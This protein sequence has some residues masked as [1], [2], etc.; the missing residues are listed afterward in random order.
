[1]IQIYNNTNIDKAVIML[2]LRTKGQCSEQEM[3]SFKDNSVVKIGSTLHIFD[4][5]NIL[6][7]N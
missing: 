3:L 2:L 7:D 5:Y 4:P 6:N 1:M